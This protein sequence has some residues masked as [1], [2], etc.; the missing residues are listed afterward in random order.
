MADEPTAAPDGTAVLDRSPKTE[1]CLRSE[2]RQS[3]AGPRQCFDVAVP[4]VELRQT[5]TGRAPPSLIDHQARG[6]N[7]A[8]AFGTEPATQSRRGHRRSQN[9]SQASPPTPEAPG[10]RLHVAP[11]P[12]SAAPCDGPVRVQKGPAVRK[13]GSSVV[14]APWGQLLRV[15]D[16]CVS[17]TGPSQKTGRPRCEVAAAQLPRRTRVTGR[18]L[19]SDRNRGASAPAA[20]PAAGMWRTRQAHAHARS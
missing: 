6:I 8:H 4:Y 5:A 19:K 13:P 17:S 12:H 9:R 3:I 14:I 20:R 2:R 10:Q 11:C 16:A 7:A 18:N 15:A 1:R